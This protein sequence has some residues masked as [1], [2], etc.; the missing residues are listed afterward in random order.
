MRPMMPGD[1]RGH[2]GRGTIQRIAGRDIDIAA[3]ALYST[4]RLSDMD[5]LG[6]VLAAVSD[7]TRRAILDRLARGPARVTDVAE[8]F[9]VSLNAV[10][11]HIK[12][13]ER[14]GLVRRVRQGR[15]H[16]LE[17]DA[18][19]IADVSRWAHRYARFWGERLDRLEAYF[20]DKE[21]KR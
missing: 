20:A 1:V 18:R 10:S 21:K 13:L 3:R 8:P 15:E 16:T 19:P 17:L 4:V 5:R 11:K 7:P 14:A 12:V 2:T 9:P 6:H